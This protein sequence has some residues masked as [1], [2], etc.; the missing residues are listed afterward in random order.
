MH[1][2]ASD[3]ELPGAVTEMDLY[4]GKGLTYAHYKGQPVIPFG[5]GLSYTS[6]AFSNLKL[7]TT[8]I[9]ACESV[10]VTVDVTNT[11]AV[12]SDEVVQVY[13]TMPHATVPAPRVRLADFEREYN[14][15][16]G[17][18][19]TVSLTV[20]PQSHSV[21]RD[22]GGNGGNSFWHPTVEVEAGDFLVHVGGGQPGF[23]AGVLN[24]TVSVAQAGALTA[25]FGC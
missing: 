14:I 25:S 19:A 10:G 22:G 13:V 2:S 4:A 12:P 16:P 1:C 21:V 3:A 24:A 18:T 15:A 8:S 6:F 17:A 5:F 20:A 11:G 23:T 7:N 9:G